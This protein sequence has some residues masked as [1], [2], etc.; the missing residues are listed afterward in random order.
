MNKKFYSFLLL[1]LL[2]R[3]SRMPQMLRKRGYGCGQSRHIGIA[4]DGHRGQGFNFRLPWHHLHQHFSQ[5]QMM[6]TFIFVI[7]VFYVCT[8]GEDL[9]PHYL[10]N[11]V[12]FVLYTLQWTFSKA[13]FQEFKIV[14][15]LRGCFWVI[16]TYNVSPLGICW[17]WLSALITGFQVA[18]EKPKISNVV[19]MQNMIIK[20]Q[21][22][23]R[24]SLKVEC[25]KSWPLI[26]KPLSWFQPFAHS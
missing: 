4:K 23:W 8:R 2:Q 14:F 24:Q 16:T 9:R 15:H 17:Y 26:K 21:C 18:L 10:S 7:N 22:I 11:F 3:H 6:L 19:C 5:F 20:L 12:L 1:L 13:S 25:W